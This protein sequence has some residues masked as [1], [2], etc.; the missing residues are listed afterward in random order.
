MC[1][2]VIA[3]TLTELKYALHR[4]DHHRAEELES[5]LA[6]IEIRKK[7]YFAEGEHKPL[8]FANGFSHP[9]LRT[10]TNIDP[11]E[12]QFFTW[13][14][15]PPWVKSDV[16]AKKI[17]NQTLNARVESIFDKPSFRDAAKKTRCIIYVD[18]FFEYHTQGK[19]KYPFKI[20]PQNGEPLALAGLYSTWQN[21]ETGD[22]TT[23]VSICTTRAN[24][25][26]AKIHNIPRDSEEC[27]M[28][29][30]LAKELQDEW[31]MDVK[32][33]NDKKHLISLVD[34][35]ED[36]YLEAYSVPQLIGK[37]GAGNSEKAMERKEY[38]D[39]ELK[40][41]AKNAGA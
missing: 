2:S 17:Q 6:E 36:G 11:Q 29:A 3:E 27:R 40:F 5:K 15:I 31:L 10:Y 34:P 22:N 9:K 12:P 14:L 38:E 20:A 19:K 35:F 1:Y 26:M 39:L 33:E 7:K 30:I 8:Y 41:S 28:P 24:E 32:T 4:G 13:G 21:K 23:T 16:D 18:G 37:E 25:I